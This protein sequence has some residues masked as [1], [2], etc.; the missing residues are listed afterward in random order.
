M[1]AKLVPCGG[2]GRHVMSA[3]PACPFCGEAVDA[4]RPVP[5]RPTRR[6]NRAATWAFG[7]AV[8]ASA[9]AGCG[10]SHDPDGGTAIDSGMED[11]GNIAPPYGAPFDAGDEVPD[12]GDDADAG[13][14]DAGNIAPP[15]GAPVEDAGFKSE[16]AGFAPLYGGAPEE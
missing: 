2:C 1:S 5:G 14:T 12:A 11:A 3:E 15:Y 16:D 10:E 4:Q 6:L 8:A 13:E 9:A 7:A